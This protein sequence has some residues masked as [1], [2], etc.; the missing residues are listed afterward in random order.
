MIYSAIS[1]PSLNI[2]VNPSRV[3][4]SVF[5]WDIY[6]YGAIIAFGFLL[7][8]IYAC[9]RSKEFG[10]TSDNIIDFLLFAAPVGIICARAYY[11]IFN[12]SEFAGNP[13][14]VL[15]IRVGGLAIYGGIIGAAVTA[16]IYTKVKKIKTGALLDVGSLGLLIG[17]AIGR[18]GN[19][20]NREA[21]GSVTDNF[22]RMGL[23]DAYGQVTYHHPTFLYESA[24]NALGLLILHIFSKKFRKFDG[25]IFLMYVAWYGFGRGLIEG[26]RTDSLYFPGTG[27]RI[28]QFLGFASCL[29]AVLLLFYILVF[30]ENEPEKLY[31]NQVAAREKEAA[32]EEEAAEVND[33][34]GGDRP[35]EEEEQDGKSDDY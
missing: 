2:E 28:S 15:Y 11:C 24:W 23:A 10:L 14:S 6:W 32:L 13:I 12:W 21:Y 1:F 4:F 25:Q 19:F 8:A 20:I 18:W 7:A 17:Q 3:A 35:E 34:T 31:V 33:M 26:L 22:F 5:G 9:K 16:V 29:I 30:R 27:L